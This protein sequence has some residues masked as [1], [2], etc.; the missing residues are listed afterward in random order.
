MRLRN[1]PECILKDKHAQLSEGHLSAHLVKR[2]ISSKE[3]R[4]TVD[5][6]SA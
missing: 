2:G 5:K 4:K 3:R 6:E 1:T